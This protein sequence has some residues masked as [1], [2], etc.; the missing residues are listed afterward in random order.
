MTETHFTPR[1]MQGLVEPARIIVAPGDGI[2]PE[3]MAATLAVMEAAGASLDLRPIEIGEAMYRRGYSSGISPDTW[4]YIRERKVILKGPIT[5]PQGSGVKSLNVTLRKTLGLYANVRPCIAYDPYIPIRHPHLDVV[6]IRENE[7]DLYA[8]IEHRQT[9]QVVQCLKLIT[10]P[11]S[12]KIVRF[13]FEY[14]RRRNRQ[15]VTCFVKD[16][17]MKLTDGLFRQVFLEIAADYPELKTESMIVD[18]GMARLANTPQLFDVI[19]VP[20]LYGDI[21]SDIAAEISGSVGLA[22]SANIGENYAM[23]EAIHGSAPDIAGKDIANPSGLLLSAV[24]ML[25]HLGQGEVAQRIHNA[26]MAT[27]EDGV[28]TADLYRAAV[29]Q[30]RVGTRE[31]AQAV[32]ERLGRT[33]THLRVVSYANDAM[34][35]IRPSQRPKALKALVGLDVFLDDSNSSPEEIAHRLQEIQTN[36][37][38]L[39]MITNRGVKVWPDGFP[40]TFLTD[41]WRCRFQPEDKSQQVSHAHIVEL[42]SRLAEHGVDFIKTEHLYTF[43]G[44]PGFSL[45]QGQ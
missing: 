3:I 31:F 10:R 2:G 32:I 39:V 16:N 17:I 26:W 11:G 44:Q 8:G 23:F 37:L 25:A 19:V 35:P 36:A 15:K 13:A 4:Q 34:P 14:A 20:N 1:I 6:I 43:D 30:K 41:H 18:I 29:G 28:Q 45:G 40:E 21:L 42:L 7:E 12:E 24:K 9:D 5:T 22:P 38:R 33:P 27:I